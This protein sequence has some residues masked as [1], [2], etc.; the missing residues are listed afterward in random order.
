MASTRNKN[1][2]G[3]YALHARELAESRAYDIYK[4]GARPEKD[5]MPTLG[6]RPTH[7]SR[8]SLAYNPVEIESMLFG[9]NANNLVDPQPAVRPLLKKLDTV[10]FFPRL[11]VIMPQPLV[12]EKGQRPWPV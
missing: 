5:V 12:I 3:N 10:D 11:P 2:A 6:Y 1:T 8:D 7:M 9:I 4:P